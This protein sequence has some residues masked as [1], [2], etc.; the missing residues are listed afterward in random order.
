MKSQMLGEQFL[1]HTQ[2]LPPKGLLSPHKYTHT[3]I[4]SFITTTPAA[5]HDVVI[6]KKYENLI[7]TR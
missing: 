7:S 5:Q 6:R 1:C 4:Q 3:H 2:L